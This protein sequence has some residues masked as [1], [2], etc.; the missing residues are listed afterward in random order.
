VLLL[1]VFILNLYCIVGYMIQFNYSLYLEDKEEDV[2]LEI[3]CVGL[4][5]S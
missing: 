2:D 5:G 1:Y 4:D 3:S